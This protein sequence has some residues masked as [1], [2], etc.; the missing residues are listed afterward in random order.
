M[1]FRLALVAALSL[2]ATNAAA[3]EFTVRGVGDAAIKGKDPQAVRMLA[4]R[5]AKRKAVIAA[6]DKML[7]A[8]A[9]ASPAV[10][11]KIAAIVEQIGDD[12]IVD[13]TSQAV[14]GQFEVSLSLALDDRA[15]RELLSDQ[16][17]AL[18]T[19]AVRSYSILAVMD[20]YRTTPKD[21][22]APLEELEEFSTR[23]GASL[24]DH[25]TAGSGSR[26]ASA[27]ASQSAS[28]LD[29]RASDSSS[30]SGRFS[31][32][33]RASDSFKA[34]GSGSSA[35]AAAGSGPGGSAS[36]SA[37][38]RAQYSGSGSSSVSSM[39]K[40][41]FAGQQA[42]A[43]SVRANESS[44]AAASR[45]SAAS[46]FSK[47]DVQAEVHDDL[48]Y[49]KLVKY[50]PQSTAPDS[51]NRT[52]GA[53]IGQLQAYDLRILD[54]DVFRSR[55]FQNQPMTL[56]RM[57]N[58]A[59]LS[60]YVEFA[61]RDARA[62][63]FMAGASVI[64]DSGVSPTTGQYVCSGLVTVKTFSTVDGEIIAAETI[65]A[66]GSGM[67]SDD[68]AGDVARK[69]ALAVG[70]ALGAQVQNYW[71]K[72][73]M[74]GRE[75]VLT[76]TGPF[77]SL[78][79]RARFAQAVAALPG[80]ESS[81]QRSSA[82]TEIELTV[83]YKGADPIDQALASSLANDPVFANLD[84]RTEGQRVNLCLGPCKPGV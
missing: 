82:G 8:G 84:S 43:S 44:S 70:P 25:S 4:T 31:N 54:N 38:E 50:Q 5:E 23:K 58:S 36:M 62:D 10:A 83:S 49:R 11:P 16:G 28:S 60:R 80:V 71:K 81:V 57:T 69:M 76:L 63:F 37:A 19:A 65:P 35:A 3:A 40:G 13:S 30:A 21:L 20:E 56:D 52:Y 46:S 34:A 14:A 29:A 74:Y 77:L 2:L 41:Q 1:K 67:N 45:S 17:V 51:L 73:S 27:S 59:E 53:L 47:A 66:N 64:I 78:P 33:S 26:S 61:K 22:R 42:S 68:C 75:L 7:G 72:R 12:T 55:Y 15:F 6:I 79:V 48:T 32:S 24:S 18:N 9:S 39:A